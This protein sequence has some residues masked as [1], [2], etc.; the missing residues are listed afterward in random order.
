MS[1]G[2]GGATGSVSVDVSKFEESE[3]TK[4]DFGEEQLTYRIGG[5]DLPEPIKLELMGIE[6]TLRLKFWSNLEELK[7][8]APCKRMTEAKLV[9]FKKNMER[10][11]K[12]Y[13]GRK[14]VKRATGLL[15]DTGHLLSKILHST[16]TCSA[17]LLNPSADHYEFL[18]QFF[19]SLKIS[20]FLLKRS[21]NYFAK[22]HCL[23]KRRGCLMVYTH[24]QID[25]AHV[26]ALR[27]LLASGFAFHLLILTF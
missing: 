25:N 11:I 1:G 12:E 18:G 26:R 21:Q 27:F 23:V 3:E 22:S 19:T 24:H 20:I 10:A 7:K 8:K 16:L 14:K 9:K 13:P 4:K 6:E 5:D 17:Y 2:Y 15:L